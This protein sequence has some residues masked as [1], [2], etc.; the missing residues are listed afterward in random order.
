[1][2][3][4]EALNRP[5]HLAATFVSMSVTEHRSCSLNRPNLTSSGQSTR[6][7]ATGRLHCRIALWEVKSD[8]FTDFDERQN[9]AMHQVGD[10]ANI[11]FV[12]CRDCCFFLHQG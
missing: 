7:L 2:E 4:I 11:T 12:I 9:T 3:S 8:K 6:L 10:R 1:M 5:V